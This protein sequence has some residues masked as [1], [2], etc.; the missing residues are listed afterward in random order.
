MVRSDMEAYSKTAGQ[1]YGTILQN[2]RQLD[3]QSIH[4]IF[5]ISVTDYH[6]R[7]TSAY[8]MPYFIPI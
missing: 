1:A 4:S 7:S 5:S 8:Q 3:L 6:E 2:L